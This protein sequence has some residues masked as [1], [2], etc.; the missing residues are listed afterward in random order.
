MAAAPTGR[1]VIAHRLFIP[2]SLVLCVALA[3]CQFTENDQETLLPPVQLAFTVPADSATGIHEPDGFDFVARFRRDLAP[4]D[5]TTLQLI[6]RPV[7]TG[8][9]E[10]T[11]A[12]EVVL[13]GVVL[14]PSIPNTD[15]LID[16]PDFREPITVRVHSGAQQRLLGLIQGEVSLPRSARHEE[17]A[18]VF[19]LARGV[20]D[21]LVPDETDRM[22]GL[23]VVGARSVGAVA[24]GEEAFFAF[25]NLSVGG[26]YVIVAIQD[27]D[28]DGV[29]APR[30]DWWGYP[31]EA[32]TP[33]AILTTQASDASD[34]FSITAV[35][36]ELAAPV[37]LNPPDFPSRSLSETP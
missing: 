21:S 4:A 35:A 26:G 34:P 3:S 9:V 29:H 1:T 8:P 32:L 36:F 18:V 23:P 28:G 25:D 6:P 14:D 16:G 24:P 31:R 20:P 15:W 2:A 33:D 27:T 7:S 19:L 11:S 10:F 22:L 13:Y 37:A 12:R 30:E 17:A 5:V